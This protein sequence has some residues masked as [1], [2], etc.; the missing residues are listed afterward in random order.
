MKFTIESTVVLTTTNSNG[1]LVKIS[2]GDMVNLKLDLPNMDLTWKDMYMSEY[3]DGWVKGR[4]Y[5]VS[6]KGER[7]QFFVA[8]CTYFKLYQKDILDIKEV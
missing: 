5:S 1:Q 2:Q 3:P 4:I 7:I 8:P 6:P